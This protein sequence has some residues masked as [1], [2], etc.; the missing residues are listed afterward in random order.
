MFPRKNINLELLKTL[1]NQGIKIEDIAKELGCSRSLVSSQAHKLGLPRRTTSSGDL[2]QEAMAAAVLDHGM[3]VK[4]LR[5]ELQK[6]FPTISESAIRIVLKRR[7]VNLNLLREENYREVTK[8][9]VSMRRNKMSLKRIARI[10]GMNEKT[11]AFRC[12]RVLGND[13]L[14]NQA[15]EEFKKKFLLLFSRTRNIRVTAKELGVNSMTVYRRL[16]RLGISVQELR[17]IS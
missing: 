9:C 11:V 2:P 6:T 8:R 15:L 1:W 5:E 12:R 4:Q 3:T 17:K 14:E 16:R 13:Y 10:T 7:R